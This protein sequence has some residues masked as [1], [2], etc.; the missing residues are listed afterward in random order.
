MKY[1]RIVLW[2]LAI[3]VF[4]LVVF[5]AIGFLVSAPKY[6]GPVSDHFNGKTFINPGNVKAKGLK[7][8]LKWASNRERQPWKEVVDVEVGPA[9]EQ[10]IDSGIKITFVN[11]STF[12]IQVDGLNILTDPVWSE[13]TSPVSFAGPRRMRPPGIRF[14][15]L[16][17]IDIILLSHNHYD[18]L[19]VPTMKR[20]ISKFNPK[21]VTPLG[22][23]VFVQKLG[24]NVIL[25]MDWWQEND[26]SDKIR[27][28]CVPAQH[29]SGRGTFDRDATLWCGYVL[30]RDDGNIYFAGDSGYG[31]FFREIGERYGKMRVS[32]IPIG[33][34]LPNWFMSPIHISPEEAVKV[35]KDVNSE[36]SIGMHFGTFPLADDG[37]DQPIVDLRESL[38]KEDVSQ[39]SFQVLEEGNSIVF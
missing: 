24:G 19:D 18:H 39:E 2:I 14:E 26:I 32:L 38:V 33:A 28:A 22:V 23:G 35:H 29:F 25:D 7:D 17:Q 1:K 36:F 27:I 20:L 31:D 11:H 12:L 4:F 13:R 10:R 5:N 9:P 16:P 8:V 15:D 30:V 37:Q 6:H 34:Y 21:I 3:I